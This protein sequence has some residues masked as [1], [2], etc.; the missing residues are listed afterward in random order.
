MS[1]AIKPL[2]MMNQSRI[3]CSRRMRL[4]PSKWTYRRYLARGQTNLNKLKKALKLETLP[5]DEVVVRDVTKDMSKS[6]KPVII[7][8]RASSNPRTCRRAVIIFVRIIQMFTT[9]RSH[10]L[11]S[12][13][14][15]TTSQFRHARLRAQ[16]LW[17]EWC[18]SLGKEHS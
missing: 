7:F 18:G 11:T 17:E 14:E 9:L 10:S 12:D 8:V 1:K 2:V 16:R 3:R 13:I 15:Y 5:K 4:Y 6:L